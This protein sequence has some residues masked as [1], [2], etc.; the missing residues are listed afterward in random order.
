M[1]L[2]SAHVELVI[3]PKASLVALILVIME[4]DV[5]KGGT[6]LGKL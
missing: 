6:A 4:D 3:L 5:S 2:L 1:W